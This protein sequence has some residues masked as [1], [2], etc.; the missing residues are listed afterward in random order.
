MIAVLSVLIGVS[1]KMDQIVLLN[2]TEPAAGE[3]SVM[4]VYIRRSLGYSAWSERSPGPVAAEPVA[5][6]DPE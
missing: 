3:M 4:E 6:S 2:P 1:K 5:A